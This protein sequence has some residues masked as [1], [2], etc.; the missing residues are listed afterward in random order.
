[1]N[2]GITL[3]NIGENFSFLY[4]EGVPLRGV[5]NIVS[6]SES[7]T[8]ETANRLFKK[9][10]RYAMNGLRFTDW[11]EYIDETNFINEIQGDI[12]DDLP[13]KNDLRIE[14]RYTRIGSDTTGDLTLDILTINGLY[15][16][17][18]LQT[19]DF[20]NTVFKDLAF[21]DDYL[22]KVFVNLMEKLYKSGVMP[23]YVYR[24]DNDLEDDD[25]ID[26]IKCI[27]M[28]WSLHIALVDYVVTKMDRDKRLL[29]NYLIQRNLFLFGDESVE[30]L[31]YFAQNI[32]DEIR[33]RGTR[34]VH[35]IDGTFDNPVS[36]PKH[37]ELTRI[38][39]HDIEIDEYLWEFFNPAWI[40]G[41][42]SPSTFNCIGHNQINKTPENTKDFVDLTKFKDFSGVTII[43][44]GGKKVANISSG[45]ILSTNPVKISTKI[46]YSIYFSFKCE[47]P[48]ALKLK[49]LVTDRFG[50]VKN[51]LEADSNNV[52]DLMINGVGIN[53][54]NYFEFKGN[55][56]EFG[57]NNLSSS[58]AD[59]EFGGKHLIFGSEDISRISLEI[60]NVASSGF[61]RI[62]DLKLL[63]YENPKGGIFL[64]GIYQNN[65]WLKNNNT[66][67]TDENLESV[68]TE[69]LIPLDSSLNINEV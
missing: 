2:I 23:E 52:N 66:A 36:E 18:Y 39:G 12:N 35:H 43:D 61:L 48:N 6:I 40:I 11:I 33:R 68:I 56:F 65:I 47:N 9:D 29:S 15:H 44:D 42:S 58:G 1:M 16:V 27:S 3:K 24:D 4:N 5:K 34:D 17:E 14:F 45:S 30:R 32:Y 59:N 51:L 21:T 62:H 10:Y 25:Y 7:I 31:Q 37:G 19:L 53:N 64:N 41:S 67:V 69:Y 55:I 54:D 38:I 28:W 60:E 13:L 57:F 26:F 46:A 8:G 63:P 50:A 49:L 20:E 22:N